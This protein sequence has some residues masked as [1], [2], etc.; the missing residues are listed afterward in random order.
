MQGGLE[1]RA[2]K[3][4]LM[5]SVWSRHSVSNDNSNSHLMRESQHTDMIARLYC[6]TWNSLKWF[7]FMC[8][9]MGKDPY[10]SLTERTQ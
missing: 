8:L 2:G 7:F 10:V 1:G 4:T 3:R 6:R 9:W 5:P